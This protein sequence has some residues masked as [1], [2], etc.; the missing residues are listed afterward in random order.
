MFINFVLNIQKEDLRLLYEKYNLNH[1][2]CKDG[3]IEYILNALFKQFWHSG[4]FY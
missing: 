4:I 2:Q 3:R 1:L